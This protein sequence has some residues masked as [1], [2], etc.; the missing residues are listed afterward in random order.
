MARIPGESYLGVGDHFFEAPHI[1]FAASWRSAPQHI[2]SAERARIATDC[3]TRL[4]HLYNELPPRFLPSINHVQG[5]VD[6]LFD[7]DY[8]LVL[9][10]GDFSEANMLVDKK[11]GNLTGVVD[12]TELSF[13]PFGFDLYA[14]DHILGDLGLHGWEDHGNAPAVKAH[15][16]ATF[17][18]LAQP[19][20]AQQ[21]TIQVAR[22]AR[23]LFRYGTRVDAGFPGMAGLR[24]R[25]DGTIEV[26]DALVQ[27]DSAG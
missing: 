15:F 3:N 9:T 7:P 26:L 12:L 24:N 19:S 21:E 27:P 8:P 10:H 17:V 5:H 14:F 11:N 22:L 23:I 16:W 4:A 20:R 25:D 18:R 13:L 6:A 2:G 1:F